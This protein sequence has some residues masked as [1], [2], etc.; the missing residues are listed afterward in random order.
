MFN[1]SNGARNLVLYLL[2]TGVGIPSEPAKN[3]NVWLV[4]FP[5]WYIY[6]HLFRCW[7]ISL[8]R[9]SP[10]FEYAEQFGFKDVTPSPGYHHIYPFEPE[11]VANLAYYFTY[12]YRSQNVEEYTR[13]VLKDIRHGENIMIQVTCFLLIKGRNFSSGTNVPL[14]KNL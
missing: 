1:F 14:P 13:P 11:V 6:I 5:C 10:N 7:F 12:G 9:F 8:D 3:M 2:G 4:L